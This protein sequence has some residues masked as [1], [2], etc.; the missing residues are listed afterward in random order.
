MLTADRWQLL[1]IEIDPGLLGSPVF[2][3][4]G[5]DR[6]TGIERLEPVIEFQVVGQGDPL[7]EV[8]AGH[9]RGSLVQA[10]EVGVAKGQRSELAVVG[11]DAPD[12]F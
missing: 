1:A 6:L 3:N 4:K 10:Q 7:V 5:I 9:V 11:V 2:V 8:G 12:V